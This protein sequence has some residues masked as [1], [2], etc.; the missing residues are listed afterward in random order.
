[1]EHGVA[2]RGTFH[3]GF[4][5]GE[6]EAR[7]EAFDVVLEGAT[8]GFIEVVDVEDEAAVEG[9]VGSEVEDVRVAAELG[10]DAG[11]GMAGEIRGHDRHGSTKEAEGAGDHALIL[12]GNEPGDATLHGLAQEF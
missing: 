3:A 8:D 1:M 4:P 9:S 2:A 7:G 5:A 11:V 12:D 10:G 6:D